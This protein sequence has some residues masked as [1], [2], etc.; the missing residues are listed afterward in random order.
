[1]TTN[2][3]LTQLR[4]V[5]GDHLQSVSEA[6]E[7]SLSAVQ[8]L[9]H[10]GYAPAGTSGELYNDVALVKLSLPV[11]LAA[12]ARTVCLPQDVDDFSGDTCMTT[13]WG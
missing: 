11:V 8:V 5:I 2:Q 13:G 4:F 12:S 10:P 9:I 6:L 1:M 7:Q 3:A